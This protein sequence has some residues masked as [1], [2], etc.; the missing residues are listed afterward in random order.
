MKIDREKCLRALKHIRL[1]GLPTTNERKA[2]IE[3]AITLIQRNGSEALK[4]GYIGY[5][6]YAGFGDQRTDCSYGMGPRHGSIVYSIG[7][8][9]MGT[10]SVTL[11]DD[12]IY[13]LQCERDFPG[14]SVTVFD[15]GSR[16]E[17][18]L[19]LADVL[20]KEREL[21]TET[22]KFTAAIDAVDVEVIRA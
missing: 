15:F 9:N 6:N 19:N 3:E 8:T 10:E 14:F 11:G 21:L 13:Y 17:R 2:L 20:L 5:K 12:E 18:T 22:H 7:R 1:Q 4:S 16:R